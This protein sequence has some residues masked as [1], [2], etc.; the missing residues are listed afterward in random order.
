MHAVLRRWRRACSVCAIRLRERA[1]CSELTTVSVPRIL[2]ALAEGPRALREHPFRIVSEHRVACRHVSDVLALWNPAA[3][4][5]KW[6]VRPRAGRV[7]AT[8]PL[9][10]PLVP[11]VAAL[12]LACREGPAFPLDLS[13]L[14][15]DHAPHIMH[16]RSALRP[17]FDPFD[18]GIAV[19]AHRVES[20]PRFERNLFVRHVR[21]HGDIGP[22]R[23]REVLGAL[24]A[25]PFRSHCAAVGHQPVGVDR[26]TVV[27]TGGSRAIRRVLGALQPV[28][29]LH[30]LF[31]FG[32]SR[33]WVLS[34]L[35]RGWVL[36]SGCASR[37]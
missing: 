14:C 22:P 29:V 31:R 11:P 26:F 4:G 23:W 17:V 5:R 20:H 1:P 34:L 7:A 15:V 19:L 12:R 36:P 28:C 30:L 18:G 37:V 9:V 2:G 13:R 16:H 35:A 21:H 6:P 25:C 3:L 24:I 27:R 32:A 8:G 10:R 33:G